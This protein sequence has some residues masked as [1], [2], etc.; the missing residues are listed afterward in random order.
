MTESDDFAARHVIHSRDGE[1]ADSTPRTTPAHVRSMVRR[2]GDSPR[3]LVLYVHGGLVGAS[4]AIETAEAMA[5]AI[6]ESGGYPVFLV[7]ETGLIDSLLDAF[8][9]P[10]RA[11]FDAL[12]A[13]VAESPPCPRLPGCGPMHPGPCWRSG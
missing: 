2:A 4:A 8:T 6:E 10:A 7:W 13:A 9:G 1:L 3:G 5:P 12:A 11:I